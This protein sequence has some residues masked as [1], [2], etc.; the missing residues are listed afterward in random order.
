VNSVAVAAPTL[1]DRACDA[2]LRRSWLLAALADHLERVSPRRADLSD[3]LAQADVDIIRAVGGAT[4]ARL[5]ARHR[6]FDA[7]AARLAASRAELHVVC[8]HDGAYP[9]R[10]ADAGDAPAALFVAGG[11]DRF[12]ALVGQPCVSIVGARRSSGYGLEVARCLGRQLSAAG[13]TVVSGMAMGIDAAAHAGALEAGARTVAVLASGPDRAYPPSKQRLHHRLR[14]RAAVIS[15]LPPRAP[16]RRWA[17]PARNRIIAALSS[18]TVVVEATASS[19]S[20]ITADFARALGRDVG[21]VPGQVTSPLAA[22]ANGLIY[23]GALVVRDARDV[24]DLL[25]G[26]GVASAPQPRDGSELEP[27]LRALLHDVESGR[28]T[29]AAL[30][31]AAKEPH[32]ALAGLTELELLGYLRRGPSGSYVRIP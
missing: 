13:V 6:A 4:T 29:V 8:R 16:V 10:L 20:L 14:E 30:T 7:A 24:L 23:D 22:G 11:W 27:R 2:C 9:P 21:A 17:F 26:A 28:A 15:E 25:F 1:V 31:A 12:A 32:A 19:G 5:L 18:L 3:L